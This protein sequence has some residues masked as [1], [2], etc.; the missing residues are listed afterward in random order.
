MF[1]NHDDDN[2]LWIEKEAKEIK[3]EKKKKE[4]RIRE[5]KKTFR[6]ILTV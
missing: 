1:T 4:E 6:S 3:K 5:R 2:D